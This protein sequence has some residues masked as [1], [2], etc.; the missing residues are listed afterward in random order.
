MDSMMHSYG[1]LKNLMEDV[2]ALEQPEA[3][4]SRAPTTSR[5]KN[6][7]RSKIPKARI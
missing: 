2:D 1:A 7:Q 5:L 3:T 6:Q 4:L